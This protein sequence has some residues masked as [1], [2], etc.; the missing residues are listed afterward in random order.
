MASE[1]RVHSY[2]KYSR[3][4]LTSSMKGPH[5]SACAR[6]CRQSSGCT[7]Q[8][9][10]MIETT[11]CQCHGAVRC[12]YLNFV[13]REAKWSGVDLGQDLA[14]DQTQSHTVDASDPF[15]PFPRTDHCPE[16]DAL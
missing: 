3:S 13:I 1:R 9:K 14:G 11:K 10:L 16:P 7:G 4:T 5:C 2:E 8:S 12:L 6:G 15:P